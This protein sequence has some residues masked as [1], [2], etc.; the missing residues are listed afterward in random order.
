MPYKILLLTFMI[1]FPFGCDVV[2]NQN[3]EKACTPHLEEILKILNFGLDKSNDLLGECAKDIIELG[4]GKEYILHHGEETIRY[5]VFKVI[6][7]KYAVEIFMSSLSDFKYYINQIEASK[8][9]DE[10]NDGTYTYEGLIVS[11]R[12]KTIDNSYY[13]LN[14]YDKSK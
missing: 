13:S 7:K 4:G 11:S 10:D 12:Y 14:F 9:T 3:Q 5:K 1:F 8:L 6:E 2:F